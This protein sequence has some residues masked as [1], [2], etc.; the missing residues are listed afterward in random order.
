MVMVES[1]L[2]L[3]IVT[4][5]LMINGNGLVIVDVDGS[6]GEDAVCQWGW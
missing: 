6:E 4:M 3:I 5:R 2:M 1:W